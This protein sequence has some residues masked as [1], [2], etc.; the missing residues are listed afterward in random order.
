[1]P[2]DHERDVRAQAC[3]SS[4]EAGGRGMA[5]VR[6]WPRSPWSSPRS[7]STVVLAALACV[8]LLVGSPW[9]SAVACERQQPPP[10]IPAPPESVIPPESVTPPE[11]GMSAADKYGWTKLSG[12]D[13]FDGAE[14]DSRWELYDSPGHAG[15]GVRSPGQISVVDGVLCIA[16]TADGTTGGMA[17]K[18][19]QTYGRWETRA[20]FPAGCAC[21]HPVLLL[22]A[23]DG[24]GGGV[25]NPYG[26]IDYAEVFDSE[27]QGL[28]FFLH[29][30]DHPQ[31]NANTRIDMTTWHNFAVEWTP[32]HLTWYVDGE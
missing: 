5:R 12:G 26:E 27:R 9:S 3:S 13:E 2:H 22:W 31:L 23:A 32:D 15:K 25:A 24:G 8:V 7:A 30:Q 11:D 1:M 19:G 18:Q 16:G 20:R 14:L 4:N 17:L 28:N 29:Y 6:R 10:S 21:Y